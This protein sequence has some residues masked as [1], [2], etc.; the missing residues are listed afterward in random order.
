MFRGFGISWLLS[1]IIV[2]LVGQLWYDVV[3]FIKA[4]HFENTPIQIY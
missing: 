1:H 2:Q 4:P 3:S